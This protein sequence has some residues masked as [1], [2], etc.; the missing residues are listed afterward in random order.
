MTIILTS[1]I[2]DKKHTS[3][4]QSV[5][6]EKVIKT[7]SEENNSVLSKED[8]LISPFTGRFEFNSFEKK[9]FKGIKNYNRLGKKNEILRELNLSNED[10]L[11]LQKEND[12][13]VFKSERLH[14]SPVSKSDVILVFSMF[15]D[16]LAFL[17]IFKMSNSYTKQDLQS[18]DVLNNRKKEVISYSIILE[19]R[20]VKKVVVD[21]MI[22]F[23]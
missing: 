16:K 8:F 7:L 3:E 2:S 19:D 10:F 12:T 13:I 6:I 15:S 18:N 9:H 17:E 11:M 21:S 20:T 1:C 5:I 4:I 14:N 22:F 23:D